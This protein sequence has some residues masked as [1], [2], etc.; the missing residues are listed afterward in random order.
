[1]E[2]RN[3]NFSEDIISV[4]SDSSN[5][6][7]I[8]AL[9]ELI[10]NAKDYGATQCC[11]AY[12]PTD[13]TLTIE[14]NGD[15]MNVEEMIKAFDMGKFSRG[16]TIANASGYFGIG[17]KTGIVSLC[18]KDNNNI[19]NVT[20]T[21]KKR[22][23][24]GAKVIYNVS[25]EKNTSY[26]IASTNEHKGNGTTII[27]KNTKFNKKEYGEALRTIGTIYHPTLDKNNFTIT[28][29][30]K[31]IIDED[32]LYIEIVSE[33]EGH[34]YKD[35]VNVVVD[36]KTY[37]I[38]ITAVNLDDDIITVSK[39]HIFDSRPIDSG[40][41]GCRGGVK[42]TSKSGLYIIFGGR[43][44][45]MGNNLNLVGREL[46]PTSSGIR[47]E[48]EIPKELASTFGVQWNKTNHLTPFYKVDE[49]KNLAQKIREVFSGFISENTKKGAIKNENKSIRKEFQKVRD[50]Q[51]VEYTILTI[52]DAANKMNF[53][54]FNE[55][56]RK[57]TYNLDSYIFN[58]IKEKCNFKG[59][60]AVISFFN[61][62]VVSKATI[63][64]DISNL[65]QTFISN[66]SMNYIPKKF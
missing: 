29:N 27:I 19:A 18:N 22:N 60:E 4:L 65:F 10:D 9:N 6:S 40:R 54:S 32:P 58:N 43:Y 44:I 15:G 56:T 64:E 12:N 7:I 31:N 39:R 42:I 38:T 66:Y 20:I 13:S 55:A 53:I 11:I 63:N 8:D 33:I 16:K 26:E 51:G 45:S 48:M 14:D 17:M 62:I 41:G 37:P 46:Q 47:L 1:M 28:F 36:G 49:L 25:K 30:G 24:D 52:N 61:A 2:Q 23:G 34:F 3:I 5:Y 57:I 21:T 35:T 50:N 59:V